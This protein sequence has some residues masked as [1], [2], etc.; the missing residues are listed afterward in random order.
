MR[1]EK[2]KLPFVSFEITQACN[3]ACRYCYNIWH[4]P[5]VPAPH[6][7]PGRGSPY[8]RARRTLRRLYQE[9]EVGHVTLTGGE[10]LLFKRLEEIILFCRLKGSRIILISNGTAA[11]R[12]RYRQLVELG[13]ATFQFPLLSADAAIHDHLT[14][15]A[16]SWTRSVQS[17]QDVVELGGIVVPVVI[18]MRENL[19]HLKQTLRFIRN[20]GLRQVMLNRFNLGGR[21]LREAN[22]LMP[23]PEELREAFRIA[24]DLGPALGLKISSHVGTPHCILDPRDYRNV[25]V[26]SCSAD[27]TQRPLT[28]SLDGD[29]RFCNHS[30]I[31]VGNIMTAPL[32][33]ILAADYLQ[34]WQTCV[35]EACRACD[36]FAECLGGCRAAAEQAGQ[37]LAHADPA[38]A[39]QH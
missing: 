2:I 17:I 24:N 32:T 14:T 28:L 12:A 25:T 30:P 31:V 22:V 3:L 4:R 15:Q 7:A 36:R 37:S 1:R 5:S 21:G 13:V 19:P 16:E 9:A 39:L 33:E 6:E 35:P 34:E 20:L 10:P 23:S 11:D 27:L 26:L 38:L 29:L 18:L 8:T